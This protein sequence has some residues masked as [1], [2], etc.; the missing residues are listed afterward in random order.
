MIAKAARAKAQ[1]GEEPPPPGG[2]KGGIVEA[3][4]RED[5]GDLALLR[6]AEAEGV[7]VEDLVRV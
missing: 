5:E 6:E 7:D 4:V 3:E 2:D 1:V